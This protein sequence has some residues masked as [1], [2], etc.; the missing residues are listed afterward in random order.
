MRSI[1]RIVAHVMLPDESIACARSS[2]RSLVSSVLRRKTA[3]AGAS[4]Q[5]RRA[6]VARTKA[7]RASI[8]PLLPSVMVERS[9]AL[10]RNRAAN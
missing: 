4:G 10:A 3:H 7:N 8:G 9:H 6:R 5:P 1:G 2:V